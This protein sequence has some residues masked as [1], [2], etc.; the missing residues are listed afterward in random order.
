MIIILSS[1]MK[2]INVQRIIHKY[3]HKHTSHHHHHTQTLHF[4][5]LYH[6]MHYTTVTIPKLYTFLILHHI[7][8]HTMSLH[9]QTLHSIH[10]TSSYIPH[11]LYPNPQTIFIQYFIVISIVLNRI[12]VNNVKWRKSVSLEENI[13]FLVKQSGLF[14]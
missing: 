14:S 9:T 2:D 11:T 6:I 7:T 12:G 1:L 4:L 5:I 10:H 3:V 8:H 13:D